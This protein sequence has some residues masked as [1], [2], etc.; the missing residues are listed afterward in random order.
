MDERK[1]EIPSGNPHTQGDEGV[2][3]ERQRSTQANFEFNLFKRNNEIQDTIQG[4]TEDTLQDDA[5]K[6]RS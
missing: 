1:P 6:K 2:I 3:K 4:I 5:W